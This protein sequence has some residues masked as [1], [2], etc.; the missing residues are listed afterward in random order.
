MIPVNPRFPELP[1]LKNDN[2]MSMFEEWMNGV[3]IPF[4]S[5]HETTQELYED[6]E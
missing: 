2:I 3:N 6:L 4:Q 1:E 5:L